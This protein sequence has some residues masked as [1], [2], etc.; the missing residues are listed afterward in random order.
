MAQFSQAV[1]KEK[2]RLVFVG[3]REN[4]VLVQDLLYAASYHALRG[5]TN[6][7]N[8][9][10][11]E[12]VA[13]KT[14]KL[15]GLFRWVR[16]NI[17]VSLKDEQ[18]KLNKGWV[19]MEVKSEEEF[20]KLVLPKLKQSPTWWEVAPKVKAQ[21]EW[22]MDTYLNGVIDNLRKHGQDKAANEILAAK[23][24]IKVAA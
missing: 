7:L 12:A 11:A 4:D 10:L 6:P 8:D 21:K 3:R 24:R 9:I 2:A 22:D 13:S 15:Q 1:I 20:E 19:E 16:E 18:F 23:A 17:P 5:N 14:T